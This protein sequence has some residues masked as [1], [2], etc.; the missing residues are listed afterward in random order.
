M[1]YRWRVWLVC[2]NINLRKHSGGKRNIKLMI[3]PISMLSQYGRYT[4]FLGKRQDI[5]AEAKQE[6]ADVKPKRTYRKTVD[7]AP[8]KRKTP[9]YSTKA[10]PKEKEVARKLIQEAGDDYVRMVFKLMN[11]RTGTTKSG[12]KIISEYCQPS[13]RYSYSDIGVDETKLIEGIAGIMGD[14]SLRNS[15]LENTGT[16]RYVKGDLAIG[17][18]SKIKDLSSIEYVGGSVIIESNSDEE[19]RQK[20]EEL[21][22]HPRVLGKKIITIPFSP[23][24]KRGAKKSNKLD[25]MA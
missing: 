19:A 18:E 21:N 14:F 22:F 1:K 9:S 20:L 16:I 2:N 11:I 13:S 3:Y 17:A 24:S 7:K 12:E 10:M 6:E 4:A 23:P 25:C 15:S 5:K 8:D